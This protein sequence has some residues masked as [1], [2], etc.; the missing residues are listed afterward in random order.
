MDLIKCGLVVFVFL[1]SGCESGDKTPKG[2]LTGFIGGQ[3]EAVELTLNNS[4]S[5]A[6][7]GYSSEFKFEALLADGEP[8]MVEVTDQ[9]DSHYCEVR[10]GSGTYSVENPVPVRVSCDRLTRGLDGLAIDSFAVGNE[11]VCVLSTGEVAC[12]SPSYP[13][14]LPGLSDKTD[15]YRVAAGDDFSCVAGPLGVDCWG[16]LDDHPVRTDIPAVSGQVKELAVD[17]ANACLI[18]DAGIK[19]W[20]TGFASGLI[21]VP[22][23]LSA[24]EHLVVQGHIAC[25][26]DVGVPICWGT[27]QLGN[28]SSL[29]EVPEGLTGVIDIALNYESVCAV[30]AGGVTCWP[31]TNELAQTV[32]AGLNMPESIELDHA[33]AC[34]TTLDGLRCWGDTTYLYNF[35]KLMPYPDAFALYTRLGCAL[36]D[37]AFYCFGMEV[38][39]GFDLP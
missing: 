17:Y 20:G 8:Y 6:V 23:G 18:D 21:E 36:K 5:V 15:L 35:D 28:V 39:N 33:A 25:V 38:R 16:G 34:A 37:E 1:V 4:S 32:P 3:T 13:Y 19:C 31:E 24:P 7:L 14:G 9:P 2:E 11:H 12:Y 22:Q 27:D 10:D 30:S 26:V 29:T